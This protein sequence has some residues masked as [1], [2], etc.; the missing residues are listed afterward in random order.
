MQCM[1]KMS[2]DK[3]LG[4]KTPVKISSGA[5]CWPFYGT[6]MAKTNLIETLYDTDGQV[7]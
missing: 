6:G 1:D 7:N 2:A 5:K 4:D 3:I